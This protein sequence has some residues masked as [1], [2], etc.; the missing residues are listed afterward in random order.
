MDKEKSSF[1]YALN[2]SALSVYL[3]SDCYFFTPVFIRFFFHWNPNNGKSSKYFIWSLLCYRHNKLK[4]SS[5]FR[6]PQSIFP[7]F[8][9]TFQVLDE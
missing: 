2:Y 7:G 4:S 9:E 8:G 5:D 3:R 1:M 6:F